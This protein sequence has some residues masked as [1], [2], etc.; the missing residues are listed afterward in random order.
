MLFRNLLASCLFLFGIATANAQY[1][2]PSVQWGGQGPILPGGNSA[3]SYVSIL[4]YGAKCDGTTDDS[5]A[6]QTAL[7]KAQTLGNG[8]FFPHMT[9][10]IANAVVG[11][12]GQINLYFAGTTIVQTYTGTAITLAQ[13]NLFNSVVIDGDVTFAAANTGTASAGALSISFPATPS[14]D[15]PTFDSYGKINCRSTLAAVVAP[16]PQTYTNCLTLAGSW[17]GV[18]YGLQYNGPALASNRPAPGTSAILIPNGGYTYSAVGLGI[19]N[20][21]SYQADIALSI[22]GYT[23]GIYLVEPQIVNSNYGIKVGNATVSTSSDTYEGTS[24]ITPVGPLYMNVFR[25]LGGECNTFISCGFFDTAQTVTIKG[26]HMYNAG[27]ATTSDPFRGIVLADSN[28]AMLDLDIGGGAVGR[29]HETGVLLL[30]NAGGSAWNDIRGTANLV[31]TGVTIGSGNQY[32]SIDI[33]ATGG[34]PPL[35][36]NSENSSNL[37]K[38]EQS[39]GS[40]ATTTIGE[41]LIVNGSVEATE[42]ALAA[43]PT[44]A[45]TSWGIYANI[46]GLDETDFYNR[47]NTGRTFAWLGLNSSAQVIMAELYDAGLILGS[48]TAIATTASGPFF[49]LTTSAGAPTGL[50]EAAGAGKTACEYDTTNHKIWCY[51]QPAGAWKYWTG[52]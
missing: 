50:P 46:L 33:Y 32:N 1:P 45:T 22:K 48:G 40:G 7:Q 13:S 15:I 28:Y 8:L 26:T 38:Y 17:Q 3:G 16:Y 24:G 25:M 2:L 34:T 20:L 10:V 5:A 51:D 29:S 36:N 21:I 42:N 19:Y 49:Y 41:T 9:C 6:I 31:A 11:N 35:A 43:V 30:A 47:S 12:G 37:A 52:T 4:N 39:N 27:A 18:I 14:A 44:P 23:E